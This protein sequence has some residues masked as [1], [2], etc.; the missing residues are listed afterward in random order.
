VTPRELAIAVRLGWRNLWRNPRR[1]VITALGL[2]T[3]FLILIVL[4]GLL[5]GIRE[6]LVRNGTELM[7]GHVQIHH[8]R[9]L[10]DRHVADTIAADPGD[11]VEALLDRLAA[12]PQVRALSPRVGAAGLIAS[13]D[14]SAGA[15][16]LGVD[17]QREAAVT[18]LLRDADATAPIAAGSF[19]I[20]LGAELAREIGV[21][22]GSEVAVVSQAAD[23]SLGNELFTVVG[24]IR[25][26]VRSLDRMLAVTHIADLRRLLAL[27]DGDVHEL[28]LAVGDPLQAEQAVA[29]LRDAGLLPADARA[30]AW[31]ELAPQLRD[32]LAVSEGAN[33]F[34][35]F[36]VA[37]F[38]AFGVMNS[39]MMAV[40]ERTREF[41]M[42]NAV[43]TPPGLILVSLLAEAVL[44]AAVGL[45]AG[46]AVG[47]GVMRGMI[48]DGWDL[49]RWA[50]ELEFAATRI[51]PVWRGAWQW[52]QVGWSALGLALA[53]LIAVLIPA[54]KVLRLDPVEAM[55][56]PTEG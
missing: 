51:D 54:A 48:R 44:L 4:S 32:Y 22:A 13:D 18:V 5:A 35:I 36:V 55:A 33:R 39:M 56:A 2:G 10:P 11:G 37:L 15:R 52:D 3:A 41:G 40:Y 19:G 28:A 23:G 6:Q 30:R 50:G 49:S 46:L 43:G 45:A 25:T 8:A 26:G 20:L 38:A 42:L 17:P 24:T 1:S 34:M 16:L 53:T 21:R 12:H 29:A 31:G 27:G 9:Y 47:A 7:L 14:A